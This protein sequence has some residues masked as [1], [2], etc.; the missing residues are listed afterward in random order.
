M[1][2]RGR[3]LLEPV[4]VVDEFRGEVADLHQQDDK[5]IQRVHKW[6]RPQPYGGS[7]LARC[8]C[9]HVSPFFLNVAGLLTSICERHQ[10]ELMAGERAALVGWNLHG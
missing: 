2:I 1:V 10:L 6:G 8:S 7:F 9:G 4:V 5:A 3:Q